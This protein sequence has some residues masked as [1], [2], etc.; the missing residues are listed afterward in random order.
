MAG[1][2]LLRLDDLDAVARIELAALIELRAG[3]GA[4]EHVIARDLGHVRL[5]RRR[6]RPRPRWAARRDC[7]VQLA[8]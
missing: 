2:A 7:A 5:V 3:A 6:W 1:P 4:N 8:S